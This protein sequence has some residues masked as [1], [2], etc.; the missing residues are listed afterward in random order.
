MTIFY[1][2]DLNRDID[3]HLK[4]EDDYEASLPKCR[5]C[6]QP[7]DDYAYV[8]HGKVLCYDCMVDKYRVDVEDLIE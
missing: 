1:S 4:E 2:G 3:R 7:I 6:G 8:I 5:K